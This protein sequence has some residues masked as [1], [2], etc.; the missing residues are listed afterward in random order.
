LRSFETDRYA[1]VKLITLHFIDSLVSLTSLDLTCSNISN[2]FLS[3]IA[4]K[5]LPL[6]RLVLRNCTGYAYDGTLCLLSKSKC[7]QHLDLQYTR[8]L[9]D[10]HLYDTH[11]VQLSS[12]LSNLISVNLSHCRKLT[13]STLFALARNC[14]SLSEIKMEYTL[15]GKESTEN[16]NSFIDFVV[17]RQLKSLRLA[18][19][20]WLRDENIIMFA[21]MFPNLQLLDLSYCDH[22]SEHML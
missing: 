13:K 7:L 16:S 12:F 14:L 20:F 9:N 22:I 18:H 1:G 5:G 19:N 21:S 15:I 10:E 6:T 2:E 4:M 11:M 17:R 8:F 3:S